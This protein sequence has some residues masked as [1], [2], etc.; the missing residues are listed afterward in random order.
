M[1]AVATNTR[2]LSVAIVLDKN[3]NPHITYMDVKNRVVKY[4]TRRDG[5]W[6]IQAVDSV[7]QVG[8]PDR[9]GIAVDEEGHPYISYYDAGLGVLKLAHLNG[10]KWVTEVVDENFAGFT[11][12]LQIAHRH[13]LVDLCRR[14]R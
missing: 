14:K 6:Q 4:A 10:Q 12:S 2:Y 7:A 11:S 3:D 1:R 9:N 5:K 13:Y 8:Y